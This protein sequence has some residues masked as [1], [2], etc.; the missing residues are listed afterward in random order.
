MLVKKIQQATGL[1]TSELAAKRC[2]IALKEFNK[3]D[4]NNLV[5]TSLNSLKAK[6]DDLDVE[7][8]IFPIDLKKLS[9]VV[10]YEVVKNKI[11]SITHESNKY[12]KKIMMQLP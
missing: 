3:L 12:R 4:I 5:P 11:Q 9:D 8:K 10:K 6:V 7:R 1:G 2:F